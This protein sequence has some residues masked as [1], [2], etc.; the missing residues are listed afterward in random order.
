VGHINE[1][2]VLDI[3]Q[4]YFSSIP[5]GAPPPSL[6]LRDLPKIESVSFTMKNLMA[7]SPGFYL[8]YQ[9]A[10]R[11]TDD[12]YRLAITEYVLMKGRTSRMFK[13]L[14]E[15]DK[16]AI[17]FSGGIETRMDQ[18]V[19]KLFVRANNEIMNERSRRAVFAEIN[20]IRTTL[21]TKDELHKTKNLFKMDYFKQFTT[22]LDKAIFLSEEMLD[23]GD[24]SQWL[25]ELDRYL[26]VSHYDVSRMANKYLKEERIL[27]NIDIK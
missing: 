19:L 1:Q 21:I 8:G 25:D 15:K 14:I 11:Y 16:T 5:M 12:H 4:K 10:P 18:S 26:A 20:K 9:L 27:I 2:K 22:V 17:Y 24:Y 6:D 7:P 23:R 13:R 3:I